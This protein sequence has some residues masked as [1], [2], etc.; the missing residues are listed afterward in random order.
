MVSGGF[1]C[2]DISAAGKGAGIGGEKSGLWK[3]MARIIGEVRPRFAFVENSP[4]LLF[5][6]LEPFSETWT[7][8]G[9]MRNGECWQRQ[10]WER[11]TNAT[12]S[13]LW[14]TP[15]AREPGVTAAR[16]IPIEGGTPGGMNRHFDKHTGRMAQI[17]LSQQVALRDKWPTPTVQDGKGRDRHNQKNGGVTLSLLGEARMYPTPTA[18]NTKANHMRGADKGKERKP[19]TYLPTPCARDYRSPNTN[20]NMA[21]Q[22]PNVI[23]GQLNPMWVEWLMGWPLGWTDLQ[24]LG[25]DKYPN[26]Q[27]RH[28]VA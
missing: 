28:S 18:T 19:R 8:W 11:H 22:L 9:T 7:R 21:D 25:M 14:R 10:T 3:E 27:Q 12:E 15:A 23:G 2:Q 16:L 1:P 24:P 4:M 13:G 17:G 26:V 6:G 5:G 20:G